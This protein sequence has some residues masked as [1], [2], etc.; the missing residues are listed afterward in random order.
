V[1]RQE[2]NEDPNGRQREIAMRPAGDAKL[3]VSFK[4]S[5]TAEGLKVP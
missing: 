3:R 2:P 4:P 1:L 5:T